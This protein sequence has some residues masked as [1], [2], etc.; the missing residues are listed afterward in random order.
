MSVE[1]IQLITLTGDAALLNDTLRICLEGENFQPETAGE[2]FSSLKHYTKI[3]E[4]N[5]YKQ[6]LDRLQSIAASAGK[7]PVLCDYDPALELTGCTAAIDALEQNLSAL[8]DELDALTKEVEYCEACMTQLEHFEAM[9]VSL[10]DL[11]DC[12]FVDIRFGRLP[13]GSYAAAVSYAEKFGNVVFV[14]FSTDEHYCWGMYVTPKEYTDQVD[15]TFAVLFFERLHVPDAVSTPAEAMQHLKEQL[16]PDKQ[17][18]NEIRVSLAEYW[19]REDHL[20]DRIFSYLTKQAQLCDIRKYALIHA[21]HFI[22]MGWVP[23]GDLPAFRQRIADLKDVEVTVTDSNQVKSMSP[24]VRLKNSFFARPFEF[25]TKMFGMPTYGEIDPTAFVAI[26]YTLLYGIMFADVGQGLVLALI[27]YFIMYKKMGMALGRLLLPCGLSGAFF[28]LVFGSVFGYEHVLDPMYHALGFAEKPI[29]IMA[30]DNIMMVLFAA[31]GIGVVLM[32][33]ALLINIYS[34][35][36]Q[37]RIGAALC[38]ENGLAGFIL[39]ASAIVIVLNMVLKLGLPTRPIF[40]AGIVPPI[41]VLWLKEPLERLIDGHKDWQPESW[42]GYLTQGFFEL[43]EALLSYVTNTVSFLRVGAFALVHAS[44][45]MVF[46]NLGDMA[47]G[48]VGFIIVIFGNIFVLALE[49]LLV[50]VQSLRLEFYEMFNRFFEGA[51]REF[52]PLK[53]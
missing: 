38:G 37:K 7:E 33:V 52:S 15:L 36:K 6:L 40:W 53:N 49:G 1:K 27:G 22:V 17:R 29:E 30:S 9:D 48:V 31:V 50:G 11:F 39:Y 44:M 13:V 46:M 43:F 28:G 14:P 5:P 8:R 12:E 45:M 3:I 26:T 24:P 19:D 20:C 35:F 16:T 51:G 47:G 42:G 4:E 32:L 34:C 21:D 23:A 25:Y 10:Q 41:V 18:I 2:H